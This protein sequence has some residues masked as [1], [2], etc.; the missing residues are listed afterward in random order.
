MAILMHPST[1]ESVQVL[2]TDDPADPCGYCVH[3]EEPDGDFMGE[4]AVPMTAQE[5]V[6]TRLYRFTHDECEK[7]VMAYVEESSRV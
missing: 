1:G 4:R 2:M 7:A 6:A 5:T 3:W